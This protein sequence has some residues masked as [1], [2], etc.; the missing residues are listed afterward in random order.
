MRNGV[1]HVQQIQIISVGYFGHA[2]CQGKAVGRILEQR[3]IGDFHLV[4]MDSWD[5][6]VEPYR[7]G[8]SDE[9]HLMPAVGQLQA[10]LGSDDAAA[11]VSGIAGNSDSHNFGIR[12]ATPIWPC[13]FS[14]GEATSPPPNQTRM[15]SPSTRM[16]GSQITLLFQRSDPAK[17][18]GSFSQVTPSMDRAKPSRRS[19]ARSRPVYSIQ[20]LPCDC[21]TAG[22]PK[23]FSSNAP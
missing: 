18:P 4:I 17:E 22:S 15:E 14:S 20:Y 21:H 13:R 11:A 1:M 10:K 8:I 5:V 2:R 3:I 9:V 23:P 12:L 16:V 7:V 19:S 6:L